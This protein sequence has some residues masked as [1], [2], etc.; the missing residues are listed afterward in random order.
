MSRKALF[1]DVDGTLYSEVTNTI[2]ESTLRALALARECGHLIFINTGR[3]YS[4]TDT[5]RE[6]IEAD[7]WL[8]GCGTYVEAGGELLYYKEIEPELAQKIRELVTECDVDAFLEGKD[9]C[10]VPTAVSRFE[11]GNAIRKSIQTAVEDNGWDRCKG[12]EK[13]CVLADEKSNKAKFFRG[14][15]DEID[16]INRGDGFYECIPVGHSKATAIDMILDHYGLTLKDAYV[17]GD[18]TNDLSMFEYCPNAI[19]MGKHDKELE[20]YASFLTK[21]VE[22]DGIWY[23]MEHLGLLIP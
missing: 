17:F 2:P 13:F 4:S 8:C 18:S 23:A 20:P 21:H 1:F 22:Q 16:V 9:G 15:G 12:F 10:Y 19:L 5:I 7:G 3:P 14:I 6:Q 11:V